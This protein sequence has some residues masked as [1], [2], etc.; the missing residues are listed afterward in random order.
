MKKIRRTLAV[1]LT[2][3]LLVTG[4]VSAFN[5]SAAPLSYK[6]ELGIGKVQLGQFRFLAYNGNDNKFYALETDSK[7]TWS[8]EWPGHFVPGLEVYTV[9]KSEKPEGLVDM[10]CDLPNNWGSAVVFTSQKDAKYNVSALL[11]KFS[12]ADGKGLCCYVDIKLVKG[13][14]GEIL[15]ETKKLDYGEVSISKSNVYLA[16]GETLYILVTANGAS[17]KSS[18]QNVALMNFA[19]TEVVYVTTPEL[20]TFPEHNT[21]VPETD[22]VDG[23]SN[24]GSGFFD[25]ANPIVIV[26]IV[27]GVLVLT[28]II[29]VIAVAPKNKKKK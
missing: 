4:M 28:T 26:G 23:G 22:A 15:F 27:G 17:T 16:Q 29:V 9:S 21:T 13:N 7:A 3:M 20:T 8:P 14:T 2:F 1:I 5:V 10:M 12:G 18:S 11:D 24:G 19:I 25:N 6:C